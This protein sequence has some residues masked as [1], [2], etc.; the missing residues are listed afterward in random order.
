MEYEQDYKISGKINSNSFSRAHQISDKNQKDLMIVRI[1]FLKKFTEEIIHNISKKYESKLK[2]E[3]EKIKRKFLLPIQEHPKEFKK[4]VNH[5]ILHPHKY[6]KIER[7]SIIPRTPIKKISYDNVSSPQNA[8]SAKL[9]V[10]ESIKLKYKPKPEGFILG[11]IEPLLKDNMIQTIECPGPG[12]NILVKKL[13]KI[14][15]TK[16]ALSQEEIND[17]ITEFSNMAKIPLLGSILKAAVGNML[18]SAVTSDFVGSRFI[19]NKINPAVNI[20]DIR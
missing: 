13:N 10:L 1:V 11:K 5:K 8:D 2:I 12:K 3:T 7:K 9:K 20:Q 17:I 6:Q 4:I 16:L 15:V 18:I 19:I 14:N